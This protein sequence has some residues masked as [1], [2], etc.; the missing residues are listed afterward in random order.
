MCLSW[1]R[2]VKTGY[3]WGVWALMW[4]PMLHAL[5]QSSRKSS[6]EEAIIWAW[7]FQ[8]YTGVVLFIMLCFSN[9]LLLFGLLFYQ[10]KM[11]KWWW[12]MDDGWTFSRCNSRDS[13]LWKMKCC[14]VLYYL[15]GTIISMVVRGLKFVCTGRQ[16]TLQQL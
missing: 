8:F 2:V 13:Q 6:E 10:N 1:G 4:W 16:F 15:L 14:T 7:L 3:F 5:W 9:Q 12:M 11:K